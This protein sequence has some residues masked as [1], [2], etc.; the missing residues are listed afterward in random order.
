MKFRKGDKV[1]FIDDVGGG[2]VTRT[3]G[4]V[5]YVKT[6]DDF[7]IPVKSSDLVPVMQDFTA[8]ESRSGDTT[9]VQFVSEEEETKPVKIPE[10]TIVTE[11]EEGSVLIAI[12]PANP[13]AISNTSYYLY[14]INDTGFNILFFLAG[15]E[16]VN[17]QHVFSGQLEPDTKLFLRTYSQSELSKLKSFNMQ[18]IFFGKNITELMSPV[19]REIPVGEVQ[20]YKQK[21][22]SRND[23]FDEDAWLYSIV[24]LQSGNKQQPVEGFEPE[25]EKSN[26]VT[27]T[28]RKVDV[29]E[30]DL[31]IHELVD[32][33]NELE[34]P[35]I[36]RIQMQRYDR[37]MQKAI[38]DNVKKIVFIH[39]VGNGILRHE[40]RRSL[41]TRY[42]DFQHQDA[43]F[44]EY[45][46]GATMVYLKK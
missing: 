20:F 28:T 8:K 11:K 5:V 44:K 27:K 32:N 37:E 24:D 15:R 19:N 35:E 25:K 41:G 13:D 36:L 22:F 46:Y 3:E 39:G 43:S 23:F 38:D 1:S 10:K 4:T 16:N 31:H 33:E 29:R 45:G 21:F 9:P 26:V 14:V 17:Y 42:P 6:E 40:I 7:E 34:P 2:I 18:V 30:V 12:I